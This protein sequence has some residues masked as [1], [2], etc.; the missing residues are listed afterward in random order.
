[1][2]AVLNTKNNHDENDKMKRHLISLLI[3]GAF[4]PFASAACLQNGLSIVCDVN[5]PQTWT[6][7][8]GTGPATESH[9]LIVHVNDG[10]TVSTGNANAISVGDNS[11]IFIDGIVKNAATT[12]E[13][14]YNTGA[15]T[16][17]SQTNTTIS[18]GVTGQILAT[19]S[20]YNAEAINLMGFANTIENYG[21]VQSTSGAAIWFQDVV[22]TGDPTQRNRVFNYGKIIQTQNGNVIGTSAGNGVIFVNET[23]GLVQGNL[24]FAGGNDDLTLYANSVITGNIDG[25][26]GTNSLTLNGVFGSA[27]QLAGAIKNFTT[28]TKAGEGLW[29]I[30]GP[31]QGF[32]AVSIEQG[33]LALTGN[34]TGYAGT[35]V[36][37]SLGNHPEATLVARAQS[38]PTN[39]SG[40]TNNISNNG[41]LQFA[42]DDA[43][44]Y[45]G[46]I[47]GTGLVIKTGDGVLTL[48]PED[49]AGNTYTGGTDIKQGAIAIT[50]DAA[51]GD[52][53]GGLIIDGGTLQLNANVNLS[54]NRSILLGPNN[55]TIDTQ[56]YT[57]TISQAMTGGALTKA[58][59]GTLVLTGA[60]TYAAGTTVANGT[61]QLGDGGTT[62]SVAGLIQVQQQGTL[63]VNRSDTVTFA[64]GIYGDGSV[65]QRGTGTTIFTGENQY[66][67]GT[68]VEQ[69]TLQIG[70]G[71]TVGSIVGDA[72][73]AGPGTLTFN[74]SDNLTYSGSI[75]GTGALVQK[76]PGR[77]DL[78]TGNSSGF[79]GDLYVAGG[80][81]GI[82]DGAI[83]SANNAY[84][85]TSPVAP[86][87]GNGTMILGQSGAL[88]VQNN[89]IIARD[90][91]S[92][93]VLSIGN[94]AGAAPAD[95]G[96]I[97]AS[98]LQF[99]AGTGR[100]V[101]NH[102]SSAYDFDANLAGGIS[103]NG[104]IDVYA[105]RT[106][107]GQDSQAFTGSTQI[108]SGILQVNNQLGG[109]TSVLTDGRLEGIGKVGSAATLTSNAGTIAPGQ[110]N[111]SNPMGTLTLL[112]NYAGQGGRLE[113]NAVLGDD[114]SP[115][116][117]L[118]V[119]GSTSGNTDVKVI[120]QNGQGALTVE[121]IRI[122]QVDGSSD[123]T[124]SLIP[125]YYNNKG[126]PAIIS[127]AYGYSLYK[128]GTSTPDDGDWYLRSFLRANDKP[129]PDVFQP[130][131]A[132]YES[133]P[134]ILASLN[135][136]PTLQQRVGNRYWQDGSQSDQHTDKT[137]FWARTVGST[138][139]FKPDVST[140]G[141]DYDL[142]TWMV[143]LGVD[144]ALHTSADGSSLIGGLNFRYGHGD[145]DISSVIARGNI[146]TDSYGVGASL[147]WYAQN[148]FYVDGQA[149][150]N[151]FDSDI[152]SDTLKVDE[153][154]GNKGTGYAFS[155]ETGKKYD[156]NA[157]K[158]WSL[159]PQAQLIYSSIDFDDFTDAY[160]ARVSKQEGDSLLGRVG[161]AVNNERSTTTSAGHVSRLR[162]YGVANLYYEFLNGTEVRVSGVD[163]ENRNDRLWAG[164]GFGGSYN[165]KDDKYSVYGELGASTSVENFG[166]SHSLYGE[167][168]FRMKF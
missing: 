92:T 165:W 131:V 43:G 50:S 76:G 140:S 151:W 124:F 95:P 119:N 114:S 51:L 77:L 27:D 161:L 111:S 47:V 79:N 89:F 7:T 34:N 168:G 149:Q 38:L 59:S 135:S 138:S 97:T 147:T 139:R 120:N 70:N 91:G 60:N 123:G 82:V 71:G 65:V 45:I 98:S 144:G 31:L 167:L 44:T 12:N 58:G 14:N 66:T 130:G 84:V 6:S 52:P 163:F 4:V 69:G 115:T 122:V 109:S 49:A 162:L 3:S 2:E 41:I 54:P 9:G 110:S 35:V 152:T 81:L 30:T 157:N 10:A 164:L 40:N 26:G 112:G 86:V 11:S 96:T 128:G 56:Q 28:L 129:T 74:R 57:S 118:V 23:G 33:T 25:G 104:V 87:A 36:I 21:L 150:M 121:G 88:T 53:N 73:I 102:T 143:Q 145:A 108:N 127:G 137:G 90:A 29:T 155:V 105:G 46:Q 20:E 39:S 64:I 78:T 68:T 113:I 166:D 37:N 107:L 13:G 8:I 1:M 18:I 72:N 5:N 94:T 48:T 160:G 83:V 62:G 126:V 117:L 42:Q 93:G 61:L 22:S 75:S 17:E 24:V 156:L 16:V 15:N 67:G 85:G 158:E 63:A 103:G 146:K 125:D 100:L 133:Y 132:L 106:V 55:G 32:T 141:A 142:D 153:V 136:V 19:G 148:G 80:A 101:L 134:Q 99:G 154:T 159:T 116:S